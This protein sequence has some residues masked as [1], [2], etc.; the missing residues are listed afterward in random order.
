MNANIWKFLVHNA[1]VTALT[2]AA[3]F[4]ATN[5]YNASACSPTI[6]PCPTGSYEY[7][8]G[9]PTC[10][11]A[12]AAPCTM[13]TPYKVVSGSPCPCKTTSGTTWVNGY[14]VCSAETPVCVTENV[15]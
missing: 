15:Q 2:G 10:A 14:V 9:C 7:P 8:M 1:R 5:S 4:L 6:A 3:L 12:A 11:P 13:C